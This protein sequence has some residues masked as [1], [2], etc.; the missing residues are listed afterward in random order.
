MHC[1][2]GFNGWLYQST[3]EFE[4]NTEIMGYDDGN[5]FEPAPGIRP[6]TDPFRSNHIIEWA[7]E[8]AVSDT[9]AMLE[10]TDSGTSWHVLWQTTYDSV[11]MNSPVYTQT[12]APFSSPNGWPADP[13]VWFVVSFYPT[14]TGG[15]AI[16]MTDD[17]FA[18]QQDKTGNLKS[19]GDFTSAPDSWMGWGNNQGGGF[20]LPKVGVN[21]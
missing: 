17:N 12:T 6:S 1:G 4:T 19:S 15:Y 8:E 16:L 11:I 5:G 3:D 20:A 7:Y 14:S 9:Y 13:N 2:V 21:A 10:S 18:T